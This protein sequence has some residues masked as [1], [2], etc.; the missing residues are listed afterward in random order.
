MGTSRTTA[1]IV[2]VSIVGLL[3]ALPAQAAPAPTADLSVALVPIQPV[4]SG[5]NVTY[6][7]TITNHGP[8]TATNAQMAVHVARGLA[9][10]SATPSTGTCGTLPATGGS[11]NV[12]CSF[13]S[14]ATNT[15]ARLAVVAKVQLRQG[16]FPV[17]AKVHSPVADPDPSNNVLPRT[18]TA[19]I[20]RDAD[21]AL[22]MAAPAQV[23]SGAQI[24]YA[25]TATNNGPRAALRTIVTDRLPTGA[26]FVSATSSQGT[27]API[28]AGR[29][30]RCSIGTLAHIAPSNTVAIHI[31]V[32]AG[33][34]NA[35]VQNVAGI[36]AAHTTDSDRT[37]NRASASTGIIGGAAGG[38]EGY[39]DLGVQVTPVEGYPSSNED[40]RY[41]V[42]IANAGP[43]TA[44]GVNL[45]SLP[46]PADATP[47]SATVNNATGHCDVQ[48][49]WCSIG[50]LPKDGVATVSLTF[51]VKAPDGADLVQTVSVDH[52][53]AL[54]DPTPEDEI[55]SISMPVGNN[56]N[57][58]NNNDDVSV[59]EMPKNSNNNPGQLVAGVVVSSNNNTN[60]NTNVEI[61]FDDA[62]PPAEIPDT[63]AP[64]PNNPNALDCRVDEVSK[65]RPVEFDV[66]LSV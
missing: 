4:L 28:A 45:R 57:N 15:S 48:H 64:D 29:A 36:G 65:D 30:V 6:R 61:S 8:K 39:A 12:V 14:L 53:P 32:K 35:T 41:V 17:L 20:P 13:G 50:D 23:Q 62:T 44:T 22:A 66:P 1:I 16:Q 26:S 3:G 42:A 38:G 33:P 60:T 56:N 7:A 21:L 58:N 34:S 24:D 43:A 10:V 52:D 31:L 37:N 46:L 27:C 63:C 18:T 49:L 55:Q 11:G 40:Y 19:I 9:F 25:L 47:V 54:V 5:N 59:S 2:I 51:H